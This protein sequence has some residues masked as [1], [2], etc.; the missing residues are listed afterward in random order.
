M[1]QL[2]DMVVDHSVSYAH[3]AKL[4]CCL[5]NSIKNTAH[6]I[7]PNRQANFHVVQA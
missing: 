5:H 7:M 4:H 6:N 2:F 1:T 3:C